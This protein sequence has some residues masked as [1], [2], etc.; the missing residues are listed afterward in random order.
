MSSFP[1]TLLTQ[2]APLVLQGLGSCIEEP[3]P[4]R[5]EIMTSPDFWALLKALAAREDRGQAAFAVLERGVG[6]TQPAILSE[7]YEAAISLLGEFASASRAAGPSK[8]KA[9]TA[10][11]GKN[12]PIPPVPE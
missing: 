4:V 6:G 9:S 11:T 1:E 10:R 12:S 3:G 5:S 2:T 7:N 8:P